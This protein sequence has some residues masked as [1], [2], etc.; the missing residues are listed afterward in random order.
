MPIYEYACTSCGRR[1][2][3]V[4][5]VTAA[6]PT[7]CEVCGGAMRK[8][9]S[10]PAIVFRGSGWAKKDARGAAAARSGA[11]E[12]GTAGDAAAST[13][14]GDPGKSGEV[15]E[16][17]KKSDEAPVKRAASSGRT[18]GGGGGSEGGSSRPSSS[19]G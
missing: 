8:L 11:G 13:K 14:S 17:S 5:A 7:S 10:P 9:L 4:H 2:E 19:S 1:V 16:A 6:G 15:G 3:V 12:D 18:G